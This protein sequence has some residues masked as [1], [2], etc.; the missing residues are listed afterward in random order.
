MYVTQDCPHRIARIDGREQL[1]SEKKDVFPIK[2][3]VVE[4]MWKDLF[5]YSFLFSCYSRGGHKVS[6][7]FKK[8][9]NQTDG[10]AP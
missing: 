9:P 3:H 8:E 2:D 5:F 6:T 1:E 7:G 4:R 10:Q